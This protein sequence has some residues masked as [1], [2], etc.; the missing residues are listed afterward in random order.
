[1]KVKTTIEDD[2]NLQESKKE[3][4][5]LLKRI[6][7]IEKISV[8]FLK[9][10]E[11]N[12]NATI[13]GFS[14]QSD[15]TF[16]SDMSKLADSLE[17]GKSTDITKQASKYPTLQPLLKANTFNFTIKVKGEHYDEPFTLLYIFHFEYQSLKILFENNSLYLRIADILVRFADLV[18]EHS[19][20]E[21][22]M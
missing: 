4:V 17:M 5:D 15:E 11:C 20:R 19:L 7:R 9:S 2:F 12:Y 6:F 13:D 14:P 18:V 16:K 21:A 8:I 22:I 1:M 3:L 10:N